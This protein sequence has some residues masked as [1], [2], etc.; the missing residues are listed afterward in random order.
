MLDFQGMSE[1]RLRILVFELTIENQRLKKENVRLFNEN[2]SL[3][4][5]VP[6]MKGD[7]GLTAVH[8]DGGLD[9]TSKMEHPRSW[10]VG[11][12]TRGR[13]T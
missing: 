8:F 11:V 2:L 1:R 10:V 9:A 4:S 7:H 13:T 3:M 12:S 5:P 6:V